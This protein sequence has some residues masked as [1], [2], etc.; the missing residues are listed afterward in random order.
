[1]SPSPRGRCHRLPPGGNRTIPDAAGMTCS[2]E[3]TT[4]PAARN[5]PRLTRAYPSCGQFARIQP[6]RRR[7]SAATWLPAGAGRPSCTAAGRG[8]S[9]GPA[10]AGDELARIVALITASQPR[11]RILVRAAKAER[12]QGGQ[13]APHRHLAQPCRGRGMSR[14]REVWRTA[15]KNARSRSPWEAALGHDQ[16]RASIKRSACAFVATQHAEAAANQPVSRKKPV[17]CCVGFDNP[18]SALRG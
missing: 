9:G 12:T 4:K 18:P 5:E 1:M 8:L 14:S 11:V 7:S 2:V 13:S 16:P 6:T 15:P 10:A 17:E 3:L